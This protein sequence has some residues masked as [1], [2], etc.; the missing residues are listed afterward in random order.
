MDDYAKKK[1]VKKFSLVFLFDGKR[2][3][4]HEH[5]RGFNLDNY[6]VIEVVPVESYKCERCV[7]CN[8]KHGPFVL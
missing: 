4:G 2:I 6:D 8:P 1:G 3:F 5:P 7:C